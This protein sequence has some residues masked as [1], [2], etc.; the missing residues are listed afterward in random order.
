MC[1]LFSEMYPLCVC[2]LPPPPLWV[3]FAPKAPLADGKCSSVEA[4]EGGG[5]EGGERGG[6]KGGEGGGQR[7]DDERSTKGLFHEIIGF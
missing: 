2:L 5:L 6:H 4:G 3:I 7:A 1:C